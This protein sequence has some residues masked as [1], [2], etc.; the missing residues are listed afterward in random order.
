MLLEF[1]RQLASFVLH[2]TPAPPGVGRPPGTAIRFDVYRR[3]VAGN[4]AGALCGAYPAVRRALGEAIFAGLATSF[5]AASPPAEADLHRYGEGFAHHLARAVAQPAW[6]FDL[7]RLD[8]A[9]SCAL[10][11]PAAP[12]LTPDMPGLAGLATAKRLVL[13]PHPSLR[14][15]ALDHRVSALRE[16]LVT[17]DDE[18]ARAAGRDVARARE[19]LAV[20][21]GTQAMTV[22]ALSPTAFRLASCL[23]GGVA[24]AEALADEG[25]DEPL[26]LFLR[27]GFFTEAELS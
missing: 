5:A 1:Q 16:A 15:I 6:L 14:L 21:R 13:R 10:H 24:L 9:V 17:E 20:L 23:A 3:N 18:A 27:H 12:T 8:W 2:G 25:D 22:L 11:A 26:G 4:L 7:A 19:T